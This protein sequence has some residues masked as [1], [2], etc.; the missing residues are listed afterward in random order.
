MASVGDSCNIIPG[1]FNENFFSTAQRS[2]IVKSDA[3][4]KTK[5]LRSHNN[6]NLMKLSSAFDDGLSVNIN[7]VL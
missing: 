3:C 7:N 6:G 2:Q 1:K 4:H 5:Y